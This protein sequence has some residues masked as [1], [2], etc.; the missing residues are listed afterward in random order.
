MN[1]EPSDLAS[2]LAQGQDISPYL[3]AH[4]SGFDKTLGIVY[5]RATHDVVEAEVLVTENLLQ[6]YGIVH[7]GVYAGLVESLASVA[8]AIYAMPQ[9]Q[10]SVGLENTTSFLRA[11][12]VGVLRARA[13]PLH[14]GHRTQV[15]EVAV[16]DSE[17]RVAA[18]GRVRM[19]CLDQ[20]AQVAGEIVALQTAETLPRA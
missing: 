9:G 7:G 17:D 20:G 16:R 8:A 4:Q 1:H 14:R 13:V 10:T 15:W 5:T 18:S 19:L 6:S 12:R 2:A 3:N 11:V